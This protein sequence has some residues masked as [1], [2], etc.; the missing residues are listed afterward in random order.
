MA[1][2]RDI[3][4]PY[5]AGVLPWRSTWAPPDAPY[6]NSGVLVISLDRW[7][8]QDLGAR[9]RTRRAARVSSARPVCPECACLDSWH[10]MPPRW[11]VQRGHFW[12]DGPPL[13]GRGHGGDDGRGRT[14]RGHAL[15][16]S[17]LEQAV[18]RRMR[19]PIPRRMVRRARCNT[20]AGWLPPRRS[21]QKPRFRKLKPVVERSLTIPIARRGPDGAMR[22]GRRSSAPPVRQAD[23]RSRSGLVMRKLVDPMSLAI[24]RRVSL[25]LAR[26]L[27]PRSSD[28]TR[29]QG[30][31]VSLQ[32][33]ITEMS[34]NAI[35]WFRMSRRALGCRC[36]WQHLSVHDFPG[37]GRARRCRRSSHESKPGIPRR[38][39]LAIP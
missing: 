21:L 34:K 24:V 12:P 17:A 13:G 35:G 1:A 28:V 27:P 2:V 31:A 5:F 14:T 30:L 25:V 11:N 9:A 37:R 18:A 8:E 36:R 16:Q 19:S 39:S 29:D 7:R 38:A 3:G 33:G 15:L 4:F 20:W 10:P 23:L 6:F 32:S 22:R 26:A